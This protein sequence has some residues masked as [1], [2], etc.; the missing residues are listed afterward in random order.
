MPRNRKGGGRKD[1]WG[2][3]KKEMRK[4]RRKDLFSAVYEP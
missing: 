2:E 1:I 4:E 3:G